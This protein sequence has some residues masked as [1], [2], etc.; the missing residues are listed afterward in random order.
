MAV[1]DSGAVRAAAVRG[2]AVASAIDAA[3]VDA[4]PSRLRRLSLPDFTLIVTSR[5]G[6]IVA[7]IHASGARPQ[8]RVGPWSNAPCALRR[9]QRRLHHSEQ[10]RHEQRQLRPICDDDQE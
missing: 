1:S 5:L 3:M 2:N 4:E 9:A 8:N 10:A 7:S 6:E